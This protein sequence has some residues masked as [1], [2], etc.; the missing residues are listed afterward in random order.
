MHT[1]LVCG[2]RSFGN[3]AYWR[4]RV[5]ETKAAEIVERHWRLM[6]EKMEF[7]L[8]HLLHEEVAII[9]GGAEGADTFIKHYADARGI[10]IARVYRPKYR[11]SGDRTA[12]LERNSEMVADADFV[13]AFWDRRSRGTKDTIEKAFY[14][15]KPLRI[16]HF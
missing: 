6:F 3:K 16:V 4:E 9:H 11:H 7:Y 8:Q 13:I 12:P 5:G 2:S 1:V 10:K 14:A 15:E